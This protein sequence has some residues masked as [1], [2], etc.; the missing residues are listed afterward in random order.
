MRRNQLR[1][2]RQ[3]DRIL[4]TDSVSS[5]YR[6]R[7]MSTQ[8]PYTSTLHPKVPREFLQVYQFTHTHTHIQRSTPQIVYTDSAV[9]H[10]HPLWLVVSGSATGC[11]SGAR[12]IH[13]S[14]FMCCVFRTTHGK[15]AIS[16]RL[17]LL[18][19]FKTYDN[20]FICTLYRSLAL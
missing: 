13:L 10:H 6:I 4:P 19:T 8:F 2:S 20:I 3:L 1:S 18:L 14:I 7:P 17:S 5:A 15:K 9:S 12:R 16:L 11:E